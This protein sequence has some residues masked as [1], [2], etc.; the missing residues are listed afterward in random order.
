MPLC[1]DA[2]ASVSDHQFGVDLC[3]V[4]S[5]SFRVSLRKL[6][7]RFRERQLIFSGVIV[8]AASLLGWAFVPNVWLLLV[9]LAP[10]ALAAG[11]LNTVLTSQ[12]TKVVRREEIG[13]TLGLSASLQTFAQIVS[14]GLGGLLLED[15]GTWS[16]GVIGALIMVWTTFFTWRKLLSQPD[17]TDASCRAE[18]AMAGAPYNQNER[19][20]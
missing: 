7:A 1:Q 14:P 15:V 8:L 2:L 20:I 5:V 13:G 6:T 16:V 11:V 9:V 19:K 3:G 4:L 17:D 12:L 18:N 10:T